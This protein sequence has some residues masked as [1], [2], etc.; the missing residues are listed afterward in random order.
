MRGMST[1]CLRQIF[2][3]LFMSRIMYASSSW[4]GYTKV[5]EIAQLNALIKRGK[6]WGYCDP[7]CSSFEALCENKDNKLLSTR[8]ANPMH[9][10]YRLLCPEKCH[11]YNLRKRPH[12]RELPQKENALIQK[13]FVFRMP[14]ANIY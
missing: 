1:T 12:N 3:A 7:N 13:N 6:R 5:C 11:N 9:V 4:W 2:W 10:L 8:I 14:Y